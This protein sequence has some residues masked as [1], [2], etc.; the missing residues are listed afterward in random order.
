MNYIVIESRT[1]VAGKQEFVNFGNFATRNSAMGKAYSR[2]AEME[3]S[4][5]FASASETVIN[6]D[7]VTVMSDK[8]YSTAIATEHNEQ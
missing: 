7:G 6:A 2:L 1:S 5:E 3:Q 8:V 4:K